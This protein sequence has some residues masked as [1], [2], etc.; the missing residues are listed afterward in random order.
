LLFDNLA[1]GAVAD[2]ATQEVTIDEK[3]GRTG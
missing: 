1:Q 2:S 3:G